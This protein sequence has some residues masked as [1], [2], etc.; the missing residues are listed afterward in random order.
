MGR[1]REKE[2]ERER[3]IEGQREHRNWQRGSGRPH[4]NF[5]KV[6]SKTFFAVIDTKFLS[7]HICFYLELSD[8]QLIIHKCDTRVNKG[9]K[10]NLIVERHEFSNYDNIATEN[11]IKCWTSWAP[12]S[13]KSFGIKRRNYW[14]MFVLRRAPIYDNTTRH[15]FVLGLAAK[16]FN[17]NDK[18]KL[19]WKELRSKMKIL[20]TQ[21]VLLY[22]LDYI[23][24]V[25]IINLTVPLSFWKHFLSF[26]EW[27][28][29]PFW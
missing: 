5:T 12:A 18:T 16:K 27:G 28:G 22:A 20:P 21:W 10:T 4:L 15:C 17:Y 26:Y 9:R 1:E 3:D 13:G 14:K 19:D 25:N 29:N 24:V 6:E 23:S 11:M 7:D 8:Y 2:R